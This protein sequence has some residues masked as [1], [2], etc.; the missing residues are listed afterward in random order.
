[1]A[2]SI[3]NQSYITGLRLATDL[4]LNPLEIIYASLPFRL[5]IS[6]ERQWS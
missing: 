3:P 2:K 4:A 5:Q 1:M 6:E